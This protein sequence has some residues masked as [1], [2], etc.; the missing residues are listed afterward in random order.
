MIQLTSVSNDAAIRSAAATLKKAFMQD[1]LQS[2]IFPDAEERSL[3]SDDHF[4]A[5]I[6]YGILFG[7]V[8][9]TDGMEGTVVWLPPGGTEVTPEK[10][11]QGGLADLP[12][13]IGEEATGRFF[14]VMDHLD[15]FHKEDIQDPHWYTMVIG[16][17]P[18][19]AGRGFGRSLMETVMNNAEKNRY[20]IYLETAEPSN[21]QFYQNLGFRVL[22]ETIEPV[23]QLPLWTFQWG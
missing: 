16:V 18:E 4:A 23:S 15:P 14:T 22:R 11:E 1:P 9:C 17:D 6:R 3:R 8:Y 20:P 2:Y 12:A 19:F 21:V 10:A 13:L 5:V 7:E